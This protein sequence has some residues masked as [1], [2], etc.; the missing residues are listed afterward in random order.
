MFHNISLRLKIQNTT[1]EEL[2][3]TG[4]LLVRILASTKCP[5]RPKK[6]QMPNLA[7]IETKWITVS[8]LQCLDYSVA[9]TVPV[10]FC[11][12]ACAFLLINILSIP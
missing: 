1:D 7:L 5:I 3:D 11:K 9:G 12:E 8:G 2:Y 4:H 6:V 10:C